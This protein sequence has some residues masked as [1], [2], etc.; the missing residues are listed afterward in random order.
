MLAFFS[1]NSTGL[2]WEHGV[3]LLKVLIGGQW[4]HKNLKNN[5]KNP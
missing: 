4:H 3:G 5:L 2:A 1:W